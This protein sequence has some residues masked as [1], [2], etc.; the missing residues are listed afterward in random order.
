MSIGGG[1]VRGREQGI[2]KGKERLGKSIPKCFVLPLQP[3]SMCEI[4]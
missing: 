4:V 1:T 2:K 3:F